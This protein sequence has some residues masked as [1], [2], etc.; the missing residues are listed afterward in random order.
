MSTQ[1]EPEPPLCFS[2]AAVIV[3]DVTMCR[4]AGVSAENSNEDDLQDPWA[5]HCKHPNDT[6]SRSLGGGNL[7][8]CNGMAIACSAL[9]IQVKRPTRVNPLAPS[10]SFTR[11]PVTHSLSDLTH[12]PLTPA[13]ARN[14]G[15][16]WTGHGGR[17]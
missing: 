17:V 16:G 10:P 11:S 9:H 3:D 15:S 5:V 13:T 12:P 8:A 1:P 7:Y 2:M 6:H 14:G 4:E